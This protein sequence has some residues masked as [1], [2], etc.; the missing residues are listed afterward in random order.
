M[1]PHKEQIITEESLNSGFNMAVVLMSPVQ[2]IWNVFRLMFDGMKDNLS[3]EN[4]KFMKTFCHLQRLLLF[5]M[6]NVSSG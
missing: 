1:Y 4:L 2:P 5:K 3:N 6:R